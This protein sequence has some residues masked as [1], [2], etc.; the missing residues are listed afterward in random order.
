MK[1][2][3]TNI[4]EAAIDLWRDDSGA[5]MVEKVLIVAAI[6]LPLLAVLLFFSR[7]IR[8]WVQE[9]WDTVRGG[10]APANN[11]PTDDPFR[12]L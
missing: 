9:N 6:S 12:G 8:E 7:E 3:W 5:Q 11:D 1:T 10:T 2:K 4:K